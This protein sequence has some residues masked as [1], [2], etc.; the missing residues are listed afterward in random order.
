LGKS[1]FTSVF[2]AKK[3]IK[4]S[5]NCRNQDF[6]H[7]LPVD[8]NTNNYASRSGDP[9]TE[10]SGIILVMHRLWLKD[11]TLGL[12]NV[13]FKELRNCS[14]RLENILSWADQQLL[15]VLNREVSSAYHLF[16]TPT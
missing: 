13:K 15:P 7:F 2:R 11:S 9:K 12:H 3:V 6:L 5:Q 14:D 10:E 8:E 1:K 4:K 16:S